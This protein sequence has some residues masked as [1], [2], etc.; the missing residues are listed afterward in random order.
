MLGPDGLHL[1]HE[2]RELDW[3]VPS[4]TAPSRLGLGLS[5]PAACVARAVR[6]LSM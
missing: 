3:L 1:E 5:A 2:P 4:S 6:L